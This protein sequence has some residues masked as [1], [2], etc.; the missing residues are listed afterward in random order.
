MT[1]RRREALQAIALAALTGVAGACRKRA[2]GPAEI[3]IAKRVV[4]ISASTTEALFAVGAGSLVVGRSKF[5]DYPPEATKLPAVG[6]F[7]DPNLEA[8]LALAPDLVVGARGPLGQGFLRALEERGIATYFPK[9]ESFDEILTMLEGIG[10]RTGRG[11]AARAVLASLRARR[12]AIARAVAA[13]TRP[14]TLLL[15]SIKPVTAAGPGSFPDEMIALAGGANVVHDGAAYPTLGMET[16]L[17]LDPDVIIDAEMI[18][19]TAASL[20]SSWATMRAVRERRV[21]LLRDEAVLRP[22]P[23]VLDGVAAIARLLHPDVAI[24]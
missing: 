10:A 7:V 23:R 18:P 16:I 5:C 14:K 19:G 22:G 12:D 15:F 3:R 2:E 1:L 11:D 4:S 13:T 21:H 9:T 17:A 24:P 20:D 6:G 8:T